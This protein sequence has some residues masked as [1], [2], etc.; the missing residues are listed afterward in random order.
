MVDSLISGGLFGVL[1]FA[2]LFCPKCCICP[3]ILFPML[4]MMKYYD[5][6]L[7]VLHFKFVLSCQLHLVFVHLFLL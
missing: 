7:C 4:N 5:P 2:I 1:F 6:Y 3:Y